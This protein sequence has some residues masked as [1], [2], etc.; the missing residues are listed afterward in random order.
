MTTKDVSTTELSLPVWPEM[1]IA[2]IATAASTTARCH[3]EYH[4][5][6][7]VDHPEC[8]HFRLWR[9]IDGGGKL[10]AD[11]RSLQDIEAA[12]AGTDQAFRATVLNALYLHQSANSPAFLAAALLAET[13]ICRTEGARTYQRQDWEQWKREMT[14]L[15]KTGVNLVP[16]TMALS[17]I[18]PT[19]SHRGS[20]KAKAKDA[21]EV[22][23]KG[24]KAKALKAKGAKEVKHKE[25]MVKDAKT[26]QVKALP[27]TPSQQMSAE[28]SP[29]EAD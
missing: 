28:I 25:P 14:A 22:E 19:V 8:I 5:G 11:W 10:N 17:A 6:Y 4:V 9:N 3:I 20:V 26:A 27:P 2:K 24:L 29:M 13:L 15:C 21:K 18:A 16:T 23:A 12:L 7:E 1:N